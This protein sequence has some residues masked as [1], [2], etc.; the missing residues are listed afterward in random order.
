[1]N[2]PLECVGPNRS[3]RQIE[4]DVSSYCKSYLLKSG[5][6]HIDPVETDSC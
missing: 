1:M 2:G 3:N 6:S 5:I 4:D